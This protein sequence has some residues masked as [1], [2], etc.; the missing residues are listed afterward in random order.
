MDAQCVAGVRH[1]PPDADLKFMSNGKVRGVMTGL[2]RAS[3]ETVILADDDVRYT[4]EGL[5]QM[6]AALDRADVV[7][8]QNYFDPLPWHPRLDT[9]RALI[10]RSTGG[11]WPG[12]LGVR[13]STLRRAGVTTATSFSRIW[14][15]CE[16]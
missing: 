11:D 14:S 3:H 8:P 1:L 2:R 12:T 6:A 15:W 16:P 5:A 7:R 9:A 10:N 13:R 4:E